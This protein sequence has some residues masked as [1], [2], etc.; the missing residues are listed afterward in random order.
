M[1]IDLYAPCPC[2]SGKKLKF[3]CGDLASEIEKIDQLVKG[4]QPR[5]ALSHVERLLAKDPTRASLL[6]IRAMLELS[7]EDWAAAEATVA[8]Y[9]K[10]H[11]QAPG[12]HAEAAIL[13]ASKED[14]SAAIDKLQDAVELIE[15]DMSERVFE[16][17]GAVG[18]ALLLAG[19]V[20]AARAHLHFFAGVSPKDDSRALE[21]LLRLNL[22]GGLPL[23]LRDQ[24]RLADAPAGA[25][26]K[27]ALDE[28]NR[29]AQRCLWRQ[30]AAEYG[31]I[32]DR[33][34]PQPPVAYNLTLML[35]WLGRRQAMVE[36]L[37]KYA[38][39]DIPLDDAVEA[40][41]LAQLLDQRD[42]EP[43]VESVLVT[44]PVLD[45]ELLSERAVADK[46]VERYEFDRPDDDAE[47]TRPRG[48]Y[49]LL[50][51]PAPSTGVD[52][53]CDDAPNVTAFL[54]LYGKRTDRGA[55]LTVAAD[56]GPQF[57]AVEQSVAAVFG[58]ALGPVESTEVLDEKRASDEAL[59]WR[60]RLPDDTPPAH[61][62]R[63]MVERRRHALFVDW[64]AAPQAALGGLSVREAAGRADLQTAA[65]ATILI[66]EQA[67]RD[68]EERTAFDELRR[69]LNLPISP[70]IDPAECDFEQ[71]P[72]VRI[73][74]LD[75]AKATDDQ[76]MTLFNR[77]AMSGAAYATM[78][79]SAE[80]VKRPAADNRVDRA[81]RQLVRGAA[82]PDEALSWVSK[83]RDAAR[84][85]GASEAEWL[86]LEMEVQIERGDPAG[87][88]TALNELR[89]K[90]F[91][92]PGV[93]EAALRLLYAAGVIDPHSGP[94]A[95]AGRGPAPT[96]DRPAAAA[97]GSR[98]WTP[99]QAAPAASGGGKSALWVP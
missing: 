83:A 30:A 18:H 77:A 92:E 53:A 80:I 74:R 47:T 37:R 1:A 81:Y 55:R 5:A 60:W 68:D 39:L 17:I 65:L 86:L 66:V 29:L 48:T 20:V 36:G 54:S 69:S 42:D 12:A 94:I 11:P 49:L 22:Q 64:V 62:R 70:P 59:S 21:L 33:D 88:Q 51:R 2:G 45:E 61:R 99:D 35:G 9:L 34:A 15:R 40:E 8:T 10:H 97:E 38:R 76:L 93:A 87:L 16:A 24:L 84:N 75:L 6:D 14:C 73:A 50:D 89:T 43:T 63:L 4:D 31:K 27:A 67:A 28:A 23:M 41:A 78:K 25:P 56:R 3:C 85:A 19:D 72:L 79:L 57:G 26:Y 96:V 98:I 91:H 32:L 46:R 58:D 52:L 44:Y 7:L 13:A 95:G 90:H 82:D 71:L